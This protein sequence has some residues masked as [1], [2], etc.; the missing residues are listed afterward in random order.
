AGTALFEYQ[1]QAGD[2]QGA[3]ATLTANAD[4]GAVDRERAKRLRAVLLTARAMELEAGEPDEA[5]LTATEA[6]RLAPDLVPAATTAARLLTRLGDTR[7]AARVLETAWK[8][9]PHPEIAE[10]YAGVRAGDSVRDRPKRMR[11][12]TELRANHP[13]GALALARAAIDARDWQAA[14]NALGGPIRT[15]PSER[16]CL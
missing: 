7:R 16:V 10:A 14:R 9:A 4:A 13:E 1:A 12:L 3:L 11:R 5:R 8:A 15:N 2:W 6:N